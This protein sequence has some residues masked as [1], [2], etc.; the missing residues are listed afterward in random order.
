MIEIPK[1]TGHDK[2]LDLVLILTNMH[3]F[4]DV[5]SATAL[6]PFG[7]SDHKRNDS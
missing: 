6:S 1:L 7:L 4:Y 3:K 2:I 5:Q